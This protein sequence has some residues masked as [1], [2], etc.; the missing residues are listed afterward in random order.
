MEAAGVEL[1]PQSTG[2]TTFP[3]LGGAYSGALA[4]DPD[5]ARVVGAW[6]AMDA[7]TRAEI[8]RIVAQGTGSLA[9]G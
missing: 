4:D 6:H 9:R 3:N 5:L 1:P 7:E 8:V 2:K